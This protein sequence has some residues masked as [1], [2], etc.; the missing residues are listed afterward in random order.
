MPLIN[1]A[2][3]TIFIQVLTGIRLR[4]G[5][6]MQLHIDINGVRLLALLDSS[7]THNFID[8]EAAARA[9]APIRQPLQS[10][11]HRG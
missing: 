2:D 1:L 7:S 11:S 4:S 3:P 9:G 6:T 8:L 5:K 10:P